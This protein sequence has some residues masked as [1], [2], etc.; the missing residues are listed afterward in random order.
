MLKVTAR[1][2]INWSL[3]ILG[4]LSNGYHRMDM[5]MGSV[6]LADELLLAP[7]EALT[8]AVRGNPK[9]L[10]ADN[11]VLKAADALRAVAGTSGGAEMTLVKRIPHGAG[12]GGGSADAAAALL[13]LN[14][15]WSLGL[16]PDALHQTAQTLG[17]DVPFFLTG[18]FA[19]IGGFG[20]VV[21]PLPPLPETPLV[22]LQP[23]KPQPTK[24]VFALYD[25][26]ENVSHPDTDAALSAL[27]RSDFAALQKTA[28]NVLRQALEPRAPQISEA[29]AALDACGA[30]FSTMTGSGSAVFGAFESAS[31]AAAAYRILRKRWKKCWLT[32]S[33][34]QSITMEEA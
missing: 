23:C 24:D 34:R 16:T 31:G 33:T 4:T 5:L 17:A 21:A 29:I 6:S 20:E 30:A 26:L 1:A 18:G 19:R 13:G 32:S 9:I 25:R 27:L 22:V 2:K 7:S 15:M 28:G 10:A 11:L 14:Q 8:L 3:D 12:M